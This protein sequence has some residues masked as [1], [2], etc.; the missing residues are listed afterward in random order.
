MH[1]VRA[2]LAD[3]YVRHAA[4]VYRRALALLG[5]EA[6]AH[7]VLQD[8]FLGLLER[9]E[10]FRGRSQM[11]TFLYSATTHACLNRLRN[12]RNR[13][14]L[15]REPSRTDTP[16]ADDGAEAEQRV[17]VRQTLESL[18]EALAEVAVYYYVDELNQQEIADLLGCSRRHVGHLIERLEA[19]GQAQGAT[20]SVP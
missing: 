11:S 19:W 3:I 10:Q 7:E 14:R 18:P 8:L 16:P 5:S 13:A 6:E 4:S 9:P 20:C 15:L 2:Q 17:R 1:D 12:Q